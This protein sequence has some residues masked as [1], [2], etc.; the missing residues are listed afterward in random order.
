GTAKPDALPHRAAVRTC[1]YLRQTDMVEL[2]G[3][4]TKINGVYYYIVDDQERQRI[5]GLM[6]QHLLTTAISP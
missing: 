4:G 5:R 2:K 1:P 6:E 3:H